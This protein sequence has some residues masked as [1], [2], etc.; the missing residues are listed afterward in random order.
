MNPQSFI[1]AERLIPST[2][3]Q[4]GLNAKKTR[5]N[6]IRHFI[7]H[8]RIKFDFKFFDISSVTE[9]VTFS[10]YESGIYI[11]NFFK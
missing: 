3:V 9:H 10:L 8:V 1:H 4:Q 5:E 11:I 2:Y 7:E 6:I